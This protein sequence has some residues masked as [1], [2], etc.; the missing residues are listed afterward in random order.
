M[1]GRA[2]RREVQVRVE[3]RQRPRSSSRLTAPDAESLVDPAVAP[4]GRS[5]WYPSGSRG[6]STRLTVPSHVI[7]TQTTRK[8]KPGL[9]A[10]PAPPGDEH[11]QGPPQ[12]TRRPAGPCAPRSCGDAGHVRRAGSRIVRAGSRSAA[13]RADRAGAGGGDQAP[14]P[15]SRRSATGRADGVAGPPRGR[16]LEALTVKYTPMPSPRRRWGWRRVAATTPGR[17]PRRGWRARRRGG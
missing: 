8:A 7:G 10:E 17:R 11:G 14:A 16:A 15:T 12:W 13:G 4:K 1:L 3:R 5:R 6:C 9:G 2:I